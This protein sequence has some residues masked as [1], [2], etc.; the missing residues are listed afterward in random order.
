VNFQDIYGR[1]AL[2]I[3]AINNKAST[4]RL[5]L[6]KGA[7][8]NLRDKQDMSPLRYAQGLENNA[9][10]WVLGGPGYSSLYY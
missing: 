6:V 8:P 3:A 2:T 4:A 10:V 7:D 5:L 1:T 9:V